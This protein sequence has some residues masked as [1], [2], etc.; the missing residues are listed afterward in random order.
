[1]SYS[2]IYRGQ[3]SNTL[4]TAAVP[5]EQRVR[6]DI[7][8]TSTGT[9]TDSMVGSIIVMGGSALNFAPPKLIPDRPLAERT[10]FWQ[11]YADFFFVGMKFSVTGSSASDGEYIVTTILEFPPT[12]VTSD[13]PGSLDMT[14]S[15]NAPGTS[16]G[17]HDITFENITTPEIIALQMAG[18]PLHISI[19]DNEEDKFTPIRSKQAEIK[20]LTGNGIDLNTFCEGEDQRYYVEIFVDSLIIFRG[21]MMIPDMQQDFL[22]HP[23]E[24]II[25]ATDNVSSSLHFYEV[26]Y[27]DAKTFEKDISVS[28]DFYS[29]LQKILLEDSVLFQ[30]KGEWYIVRIDEIGGLSWHFSDECGCL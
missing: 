9:T 29:I 8:D 26:I 21:F 11:T 15:P 25:T 3:F 7:S 30:C 13:D 17:E 22:P 1:M 12:N 16:L 14:F 23:N 27:L 20:L 18:D 24:L 28:E 10:A 2:K 6:I 5:V 19:V 4:S